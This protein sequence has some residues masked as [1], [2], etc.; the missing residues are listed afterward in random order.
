MDQSTRETVGESVKTVDHP[1]P[2]TNK[3]AT[4]GLHIPSSFCPK[5][6]TDPFATVEW[7]LRTAAI[8]GE[9][10]EV[11]FEQHDCEVPASWSQLATN[12]VANKYLYGELGTDE[13]EKGVRQLI[14]RVC[15]TIADWGLEDGY[16]ATPA[17]GERFYRDLTWLCLH[18]HASFNSPVWFNVGLFHQ[19]GVKGAKC[20]WRWDRKTGELVQPENPYE[21]PQASACFIQSVRDNMEDIM[22]LARSEAMLFKFGSGTGT[23]IS[24]L[25]SHREKLSGGGKPSGPLSFMRVYDQ[26]AAVVKSG[27]KTRRAAKMQSIKDWHPDVMEFIECKSREERKVR[28]LVEEGYDPQEAYDTVLFQNANFSVRLSDD[29]MHAVETDKPWATHWVTDP[30]KSGPSYP[31]REMFNKIAASTWCCGDPGVQYDTTI[32]RWHTC[33]SS[34]RI[35]ASNPCSEYMFLDDSACNLASINLM[36]FRNDDGVFDAERFQAACRVVFIAQEIL[37]DH[38]NYPTKP[39]AINSHRFRPI[40]LGYSNLGSLIMAAGLPYDSDEARGLCGAIT[41]LLHGAAYLTSTELAEA[42]GPFDGYEKNREPMLRVMEMHWEKVDE[43]PSCPKY[44]QEAAR[45]L[46]DKVLAHGKRFGFRNAQAT[47]LAPTGTISFMMDC[48]TTGIEPDIA[49]VKYKQLAGGGTLKIVNRTVSPVLRSLGYTDAQI[50]T[51]ENYI[52]QH[53]T[54]EG[55]PELAPEYLPVF[56]CAFPP[57]NG[58]R[59]ISWRA[60]IG[61]MAAAQPFVSGAISKTVNIPKE[62]AP[63]DVADAYMEGWRLGL[64]ALAIYRDGSKEMQPLSTKAKADKAAEKLLAAPRRE[65]LPDTRQSITHKFSVSGHEGYITVGLYP[66]GRPGE[67]FIT[68]AKEGS[69]VGGMMDCFGTAVSMSMQYGVPLEVYV[70]KFSHTRFEPMGFTKNPDIRIAKSIVDYIFRWLGITFLPGYRE[71]NKMAPPA[72]ADSSASEPGEPDAAQGPAKTA[73]SPNGSPSTSGNGRHGPKHAQKR[74]GSS[75]AAVAMDRLAVT[76]LAEAAAGQASHSEQFA[77]FQTDA[78]ACDNCG[79]ITVRSG[80]CYLCYN[81]GS[82]MG[83]S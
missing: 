34:G 21:Y 37:V 74:N 23:D 62:S 43:I 33:P 46:W 35:N 77:S 64:K 66:D 58:K 19:Y 63:E 48:D 16:F 52:D 1:T 51:I 11:I 44:L 54:I 15:R 39:I 4:E 38:A 55:A 22:E 70:N 2:K 75:A 45:D 7:E 40:G 36:K 57:R 50:E 82:S 8:K 56:D 17:D 71:A 47:V 83:C 31:A 5:D 6:Q 68:M 61:M 41:A 78:P 10:G 14:H 3:T 29:F 28:T 73:Q 24:T 53:D 20:N 80:N 12:V 81:C 30:S 49:L 59:S 60:H 9:G 42:V 25:R 65:R 79:S 67:L 18:Q 32:N 26:I 27:G 13:R 72:S 76:V 69:T